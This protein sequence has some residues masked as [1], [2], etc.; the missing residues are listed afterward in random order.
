[1]TAP[2]SLSGPGSR[3][4]SSDGFT[5]I[6]MVEVELSQPLPTVSD[7][8]RYQRAWV[9]VR[10]LTEPIG[11]CLVDMD[12]GGLDPERLGKLLWQ[13]LGDAV[14]SR[15]EAAGLSTP[16]NLSGHRL[17]PATENWPFLRARGEAIRS[18]PSI[19][20]VICTYNRPDRVTVC[21]EHM[22]QQRYPAFEV[23]VVDNNPQTEDV[24]AY[25][26]SLDNPSFRYVI[27]PRVGL[28]RARNTGVAAASG[29]IVAFLDDD[30]EPDVFW[31]AA[32]AVGFARSGDIGCVTGLILPARL[33]T[34]AQVLLEEL[35]GHSKERGFEPAVFSADGP[36]SP[37]YPRPPFGAGGN[38]AFR[39]ETLAKIGRFDT[40]LGAGTPA[41]GAEDTL[42][43]TLV[44]LVGDKIAYE[45][46]AF[47]RHHH[48]RDFADLAR[49]QQGY[50]VGLTA[51]YTALIRHRPSVLIALMRLLP[52]ASRYLVGS[53]SPAAPNTTP[54]PP[55][56]ASGRIRGMLTG[57]AAYLRG[58]IR[59]V[60]AGA[61]HA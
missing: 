40:A 58:I 11:A 57:P 31:L 30:E 44:M 12:P 37:L 55:E 1:V 18:A 32:M 49:Q 17:D 42:A 21:L 23:I 20:V 36:Q 6:K 28:S 27:E 61:P 56:L 16:H 52:S 46:A 48:Y 19:S 34:E 7:D 9:L 29:D 38:M 39:R 47:V 43:L 25:V 8:G 33:D 50:M 35:G 60:S 51:Y 14:V 3:A 41:R 10:L 2:R 45:P 13:E 59:D 54:L 22:Q 24:R 4:H 26:A 53:R 5:G 15:F